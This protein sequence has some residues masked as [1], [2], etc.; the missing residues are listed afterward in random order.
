MSIDGVT[1]RN[2]ARQQ[3]YWRA[4]A[5]ALAAAAA[6]EGSLVLFG[7]GFDL[8]PL[9]RL[10]PGLV[11]MNPATAASFLLAGLALLLLSRTQNERRSAREAQF[12]AMV[13]LLV[14]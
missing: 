2:G 7:W 12:C 11:A 10:L 9:K 6:I 4:A 8:E 3:L 14:G 13:V 5:R 1:L